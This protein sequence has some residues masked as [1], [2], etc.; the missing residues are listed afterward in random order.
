MLVILGT[1]EN[2]NEARTEDYVGN[3]AKERI[4]K[5]VV[6]ENKARQVFRRANISYPLDMHTCI[7]NLVC[8]VFLKHPFK[9]FLKYPF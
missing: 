2:R 8:S 5:R 1:N 6:Q 3:E 4:S 9:F 7:S